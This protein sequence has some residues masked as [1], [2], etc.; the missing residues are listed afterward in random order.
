MAGEV[1]GVLVGPVD[2]GVHGDLPVDHPGRIGFRQDPGVDLVPGSVAAEEAMAFPECLPRAEGLRQV[3]PR[4]PRPERKIMP[5][6]IRRWSWNGLP[7]LPSELGINGS[8]RSHWASV[9][10]AVRDMIPACQS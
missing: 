1:V 6:T 3:A 10:T 2:R 7:R 5:S 4:N 8:I 9:R